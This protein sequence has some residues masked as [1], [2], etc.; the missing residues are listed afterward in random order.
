MT[1]P[2]PPRGPATVQQASR[3]SYVS[4][5]SND[6]D[7]TLR[8]PNLTLG[9]AIRVLQTRSGCKVYFERT[10]RGISVGFRVPQDASQIAPTA[11]TVRLN[12]HSRKPDIIEAKRDLVLTCVLGGV[13]GFWGLPNPAFHQH[14]YNLRRLV[15]LNATAPADVWISAASKCRPREVEDL[16]VYGA[17]MKVNVL[18]D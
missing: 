7:P 17:R 3:P 13:N 11:G 2:A 5:L 16:N 9:Q 4:V 18:R 15:S 10:E 1:I 12:I 14:R 8:S 6:F